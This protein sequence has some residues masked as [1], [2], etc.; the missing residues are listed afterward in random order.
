MD[1]AG[2][3]RRPRR[4]AA[5]DNGESDAGEAPPRRQRV[6]A[7]AGPQKS[8]SRKRASDGNRATA[9]KKSA[10]KAKPNASTASN[11]RQR[12]SNLVQCLNNSLLRDK[13]GD[14]RLGKLKRNLLARGVL[15]F[16]LDTGP[17]PE[18]E[19]SARVT[20]LEWH[21]TRPQLLAVG[22]KNG[23]IVLWNAWDSKKQ[24][25]T[26]PTGSGS[27]VAAMKFHPENAGQMYTATLLSKVMLQDFGGAEPKVF[28]DTDSQKVWFTSMDLLPEKKLVLAGDNMGCVYAFSSTGQVLWPEPRRLHKGKVKYLEFVGRGSDLLVSASVDHTVRIWDVRKLDGPKSFL[29]ELP[30]DQAV[31]SAYVSP[32]DRTSLL[33]TDQKN[34]LRVYTGPVWQ[35]PLVIPHPHRQF[36]HVTPIQA[37]WHPVEN[38]VVVGRYPDKNFCATDQTR[39]IDVFD[40]G[41][42]EPLGKVQGSMA[43]PNI[44]SL[45]PFNCTGEILAAGTGFHT[46]LLRGTPEE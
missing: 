5:R 9:S 11:V 33:T 8:E 14:Q 1:E 34:E 12:K 36:Q 29:L 3:S 28:W 31:N 25:A 44:C 27:A 10:G 13:F 42:G 30:H 46:V 21:P 15:G 38:L 39:G 16:E 19:H 22:S 41:T 18:F 23:E 26:P 40:G 32:S 37:S 6:A 20:C 2:P 35:K 4:R 45:T 7:P 43:V 24:A 17:R